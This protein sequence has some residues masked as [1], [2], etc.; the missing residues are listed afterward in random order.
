MLYIL[1]AKNTRTTAQFAPSCML[2]Q[3]HLNISYLAKY[4][5]FPHSPPQ[6]RKSMPIL[7]HIYRD[8]FKGNQWVSK[9]QIT[10]PDFAGHLQH[11]S[12]ITAVQFICFKM[13]T[14]RFVLRFIPE[15][16][17]MIKTSFAT[18]ATA[19]IVLIGLCFCL[20]SII[21]LCINYRMFDYSIYDH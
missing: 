14:N 15:K 9:S 12:S 18:T 11:H 2:N 20:S 10:R 1:K 3:I 7:F 21:I 16:E 13:L 8:P 5:D 4:K 19:V 6:K 17:Q